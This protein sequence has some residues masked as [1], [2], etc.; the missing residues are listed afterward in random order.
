M[1]NS[2][3]LKGQRGFS[4]EVENHEDWGTIPRIVFNALDYEA[5]TE[6]RTSNGVPISTSGRLGFRFCP[7]C[8]RRV[9]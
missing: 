2:I 7:W 5:E 9:G 8:G 6:V 3:A 1:E 4:I